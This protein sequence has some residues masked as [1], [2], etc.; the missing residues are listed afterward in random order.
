M[1]EVKLVSTEREKGNEFELIMPMGGDTE[2]I[3]AHVAE[4]FARKYD[5]KTAAINQI[6]TALIEACINAA[7]HSL[8]P[9]RKIH[10]KFEMQDDT[11]VITISNRGLQIPPEKLNGNKPEENPTGRRGLGLRLIRRL[12]DEVEF[13]RTE[14]GTIIRM[15]KRR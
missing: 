10:Q 15:T 1:L 9:D 8:S 4:D 11:L 2:L 3:S 6:K 14:D 12:M 13:L 5:F 7:E